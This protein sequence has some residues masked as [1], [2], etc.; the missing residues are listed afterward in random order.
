MKFKVLILFVLVLLVSACEDD[1]PLEAEDH[2]EAVGLR[3]YSSGILTAEIFKGITTD[4]LEAIKGETSEHLEVIFLD[5]DKNEVDPPTDEHML[6]EGVIADTNL[7]TVWQHPG[8]EGGYEF[9]LVGKE[10]GITS[11]ELFVKHNDHPDYRSGDIP[12]KVIS[13]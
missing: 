7:A 10:E 1:S 2:F 11:I 4:T 3:L 13:Q 6:F 12:V 5:E 8:E 9:H